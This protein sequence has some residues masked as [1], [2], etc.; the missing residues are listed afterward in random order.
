M[1]RMGTWR[2]ASSART[3]AARRRPSKPLLAALTISRSARARTAIIA[4]SGSASN[5]G[6]LVE[7]QFA[8]DAMSLMLYVVG[9]HDPRAGGG[10]PRHRPFDHAKAATG[11]L[12]LP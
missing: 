6:T 9:H 11:G 12:P 1:A 10:K 4:F 5:I 3:W 2:V 8:G 7:R